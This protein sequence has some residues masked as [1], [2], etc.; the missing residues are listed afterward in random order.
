HFDDIDLTDVM[1]LRKQLKKD[2]MSITV[3]AFLLKALV[4]ALKDFPIFNA[5]LD[6]ENEQ[7]ILKKNYHIGLATNTT[8]GLM[9]PVVHHVDHKSIVQL[10]YDVKRITNTAQDVKIE[11]RYIQHS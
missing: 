9:V 8:A 1:K 10:H 11:Y 3:P 4:I 5:E 2:G 7:I 6:E